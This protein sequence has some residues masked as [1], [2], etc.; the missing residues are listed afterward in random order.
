MSNR[1]ISGKLLFFG[2]LITG[3]AAAYYLNTKEGKELKNKVLAK[4]NEISKDLTNRAGQIAEQAKE[5][6][7]IVLK[8]A[9]ESLSDLKDSLQS[10]ANTATNAA[11]NKINN[12]QKGINH[13]KEKLNNINV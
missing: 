12:F 8:N 10:K 3:A 9:S 6:S 2:G 4:G 5:Q 1:N 13:A 7:E 11:E